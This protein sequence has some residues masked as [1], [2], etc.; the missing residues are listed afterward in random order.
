[1]SQLIAQIGAMAIA[2][3]MIF[4]IAV[5]AGAPYGAYTQRGRHP[6]VLP[7]AGRIVAAVSFLVLAV[8]AAALLARAGL[9]PLAGA[10]PTLLRPLWWGSLAVAI[11]SAVANLRSPSA[12]ERRM[13]GPVSVL[14]ILAFVLSAGSAPSP[15]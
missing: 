10:D 12:D 4:Q 7:L 11:L 6:G 1:V 9:G 14:I 3:V 13:F 8:M 15:F 5:L 2:A